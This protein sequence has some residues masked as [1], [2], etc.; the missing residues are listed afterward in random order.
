MELK[1]RTGDARAAYLEGY[2]DGEDH[3]QL[4]VFRILQK[5]MSTT[6]S[7]TAADVIIQIYQDVARIPVQRNLQVRPHVIMEHG[8]RTSNVD[9]EKN[10]ENPN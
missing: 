3:I 2:R 1:E 5:H 7:G 6:L 4:Q 8:I 10:R 9:L